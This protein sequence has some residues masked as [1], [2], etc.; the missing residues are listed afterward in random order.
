LSPPF[1]MLGH[2]NRGY[3]MDLN[4]DKGAVTVIAKILDM[5]GSGAPEPIEEP[6]HPLPMLKGR[7]GRGNKPASKFAPTPLSPRMVLLRSLAEDLHRQW[8]S[9][10]RG[11]AEEKLNM[12]SRV[13]L[14]I[15]CGLLADCAHPVERRALVNWL[16]ANL[17]EER[18]NIIPYGATSGQPAEGEFSST[19]ARSSARCISSDSTRKA[20]IGSAGAESIRISARIISLGEDA[21]QLIADWIEGDHAT[22]NEYLGQV[23]RMDLGI[24]CSLMNELVH[25][26]RRP[27]FIN[28][29][30]AN[31]GNDPRTKVS[32]SCERAMR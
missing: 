18:F 9:G 17:S 12:A 3:R 31:L 22:V 21:S 11:V 14:G 29:L 5:L 8:A 15:L 23:S 30:E 20:P 19:T 7:R 24:L 2:K 26:L 4:G 10:D 1:S 6:Q 32:A 28:W 16:E 25:P 27:E 13:E